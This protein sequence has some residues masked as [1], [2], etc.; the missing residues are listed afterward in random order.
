MAALQAKSYAQAVSTVDVTL[1]E[2]GLAISSNLFGIFFE[3]I[4]SAGDGGIY[5]ELIRNRSFE[6]TTNSPAFWSFAQSGSAAGYMALDR[7]QPMSAINVQ[8]LALTMTSGTGTVGVANSGYWGVPV[9]VGSAYDLSFYARGN[10]GAITASLERA[11]GGR[12]YDQ[13][14]VDGITA[15]WQRFAVTLSPDTTD[16]N[17]RLVLRVSQ[18]GTVV[19]D[20]VSLFPQATFH[21]RTNGLR[22]DLLGKLADLRPAFMRFP[23][24]SFVDG[25]D[26]ANAYH[27][28]PTCG[29]LPDRP[30]RTNYWRYMVSNG[31]GY[32]EYLQ[33]CEDLGAQPLFNANAGM[34]VNQ[35]AVPPDQLGPW[36]QE[37]LDAIEYANGETNTVYGQQ[38]ALNGHPASFN[39]RY[40]EIGNENGGVDYANNYALFYDAIKAKYPEVHVIAC[41]WGSYPTSRPVEIADEHYYGSAGVILSYANRFDTYNRNGPK[42][43]VGEYAVA[44]SWGAGFPATL[45]NALAEA[46]F[47]AGMERNSDIVSL[48]CYAPLFANV[49]NIN[50]SPNLIYFDAFRAYGTPSYHVQKLF[51]ENRADWVL[52]ASV[53]NTNTATNSTMSGGIGVGAWTTSVQ[54]SNVVVTSNGITLYESDFAGG[55]GGWTINNG[56]WLAHDGVF[57]QSNAAQS[58]CRATTGN[59]AWANYTVSLKARKLGGS[60]GFLVLFNCQDSQNWTWWNVGGWGNSMAG[61]EQVVGGNRSTYARVSLPPIVTNQWYDIRVV[62]D[63]QHIRCYLGTNAVQAATNLVQDVAYPSG[64]YVTATQSKSEG[65]TIIKAVNPYGTDVEATFRLTGAQSVGETATLITL[66]SPSSA[67]LNSLDQPTF[68]SPVTN[69]VAAGSTNFSLHLPAYSFNIL[70]LAAGG[71]EVYTNLAFSLVSDLKVK[72]TAVSAVYGQKRGGWFNLTPNKNHA[73]TYRSLNPG[74]ATVDSAGIVTGVRAGQTAIVA[75]YASLGLAATQAVDVLNFPRTL[76]HRYSFDEQG[77][78][79]VA[80][81]IGGAAWNGSLPAGGS[82]SDGQLALSA[83]AQQYV[84]LPGDILRGYTAV[85]LDA[86]VTFPNQLPVNCFFFGFGNTNNG[87]G[88]GYLF[89]APRL[90][91]IAFT[92]TDYN[93]EQ[94]AGPGPDLSFQTNLHL[95]AIFNPPDGYIALYTNGAL[96][97]INQGVTVPLSSISNVYSYIGRSLYSVDPYPDMIL[98]EFRIYS[99]EL[100]P[101]EILA[102]DALGPKRLLMDEEPGVKVSQWGD[103]IRMTWPAG[104]ADY[105]V[106]SAT[107][108]C[109]GCWRPVA[110]T[111]QLV[112]GEWSVEFPTDG[113]RRY[114]R[115]AK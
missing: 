79:I 41:A 21:G 86:W 65:A 12:V 91:R 58:D 104:A 4:S 75:A 8:A 83:A 63:G 66:T 53:S 26:L 112:D 103:K 31:L 93:G 55:S 38:R 57:E 94:S 30:G 40:V 24:G 44:Y 18:P 89:C 39:L 76:V 52:P 49:N 47:M 107:N 29:F 85:T 77:G 109:Q 72:E 113:G 101:N 73:I 115:L 36:V 9:R 22:P 54:Y 42:I 45:K 17:A 56:N 33:M 92:K 3:E 7:S 25:M 78:S 23:G 88:A 27:W 68:V 5:A 61:I 70:R 106:L 50:W 10:L 43:F 67:D 99:R 14:S 62:L 60:E 97:A 51:A 37:V 80:D 110:I 11:D 20:F 114:F 28:K 2:P 105:A 46:V 64:L 102:S 19:L 111:P 108:L 48:S 74:I 100:S 35:N 69:T 98:D 6:D 71:M 90:G 81:S 16:A 87:V 1:D 82:F 15:G 96:S 84:Q 32:H 34:D 13:K 95:T 59:P